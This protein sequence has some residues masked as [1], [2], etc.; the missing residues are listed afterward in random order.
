MLSYTEHQMEEMGIRTNGVRDVS[1]F[2]FYFYDYSRLYRR[3]TEL[4]IKY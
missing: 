1:G 3:I 4:R 2:Y